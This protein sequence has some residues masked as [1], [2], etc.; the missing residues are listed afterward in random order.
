MCEYIKHLSDKLYFKIEHEEKSVDCCGSLFV[1]PIPDPSTDPVTFEGNSEVDGGCVGTAGTT[2][3]CRDRNLQQVIVTPLAPSGSTYQVTL[4]AISKGLPTGDPI[5]QTLNIDTEGSV[6]FNLCETDA[7]TS[8]DFS[9]VVDGGAPGDLVVVQ[10]LCGPPK[11][12]GHKTK[13]E[14]CTGAYSVVPEVEETLAGEPLT[15][16]LQTVGGGGCTCLVDEKTAVKGISGKV[17]IIQ[18]TLN[19]NVTT[20]PSDFTFQLFDSEGV[21]AS[22]P[23]V[24]TAIDDPEALTN[25]RL[26]TYASSS[27]PFSIRVTSADSDFSIV[28]DDPSYVQ[29][30]ATSHCSTSL[31]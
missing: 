18:L 29:V 4:Q 3:F 26:A 12:P 9:L 31:W 8:A 17:Q 19:V 20:P 15:L 10:V 7:D 24:V 22:D 14:C 1:V 21:A 28:V 5:S 16:T 6:V 30:I 13:C 25:I 2:F 11:C 27:G 23:V